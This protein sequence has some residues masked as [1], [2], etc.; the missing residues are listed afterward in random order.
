M[1]NVWKIFEFKSFD[2]LMSKK[3]DDQD[4]KYKLEFSICPE[5]GSTMFASM[6]FDD[7]DTLHKAFDA[8]T[9]HTAMQMVKFLVDSIE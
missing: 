6:A 4:E 5:I 7:E 3:Y 9:K 2:V 1:K 8:V